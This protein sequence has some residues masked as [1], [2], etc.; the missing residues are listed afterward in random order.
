MRT[1]DL[2]YST[3]KDADQ[4]AKLHSLIGVIV[5]RGIY[6]YYIYIFFFSQF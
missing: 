6:I 4:T 2:L 3:N 5:V 1:P